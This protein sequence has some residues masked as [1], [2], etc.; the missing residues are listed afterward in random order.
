MN[1]RRW[2]PI[3]EYALLLGSGAG[4]ITSIVTQNA[5]AASLPVTALVAFGLLNKRRVEQGLQA[6]DE[7]LDMLEDRVTHEV[8]DLANQ[9]SAL[10]T[11]ETITQVQRAAMEHSDSAIIRFSHVL[12]QTK[13]DM[14]LRLEE[15]ESPDLSHLYQDTAQL[16]DQYTYVC[17]AISNLSKQIEHLSRLP[18]ME[19]T[20]ADVTHLKTELMQMRVNLETLKSESKTAQATLHDAVRHLD[21]RLRRVPHNADPSMLK[22]EV[23]ELVKA[24]GDLVPRRE[25]SACTEKLQRVYET[26]ENL[27]QTVDRLQTDTSLAEQNGHGEGKG[28]TLKTLETDLTALTDAV[29][30]MEVRLADIAVPFDITTEIRAT[31]A[32]Y[33]SSL[34]W[35]LASLEQNTQDLIQKQQTLPSLPAKDVANH[36][37][38]LAAQNTT[39]PAGENPLQWLM[40]FRSDDTEQDWSNVDQALLQV[41][42]EV[43]ERA[44][45]VWPWS[46]AMSLDSRLIERFTEILE[47][48]CRLEIGWCHP[49][50]RRDGILLKTIAQQWEVTTA[51]RKLLKSTLNQLLP[52]KKKY[53]KHFSFKILGTNEQFLVCD[54][55]YAIVGLQALRAAS[56]T[57]PELDLRVKTL[58][59]SVIKRL[60]NRFDHPDMLTEDTA[61][62]FNRAVT[63][64]DLKDMAGAIADFSEVMNM[65]PDDA[66]AANNRGV[67]WAEKKQCQRAVEDFDQA[68]GLDPYLFAA[69]CNRGWLRLHQNQ[70]EMAVDDFNQAIK[71]E[72]SQAIPY[73]YRGTGRQK[74]GDSLGAI[75]DYTKTIQINSQ[76]AFP[77]CYRGAAYQ[78]QGNILGAITDLEMAASL[79]HAKEDH[80]ALAQVTQILSSLK[81]SEFTQQPLRLHS[82]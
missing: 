9:I 52:L 43:S 61:A 14:R 11:P 81:Q 80:R 4:A 55:K 23:R 28:T 46:S 69:R 3:T 59:A 66:V 44:V 5:I 77:Y 22:G 50:D 56:S 16:Q 76:V 25:F 70:P 36:G 29:E 58:E 78:R 53:P 32:T 2:L 7:R 18:R 19:A 24:V 34:Q 49:G 1:N 47:R 31:T 51:E 37:A 65:S 33:L 8:I 74:L 79:L 40:A 6:N 21:R 10:P 75:A 26:Q 68:I 82:A 73:F 57:F 41:L 60:L 67:I 17:T 30:Q 48:G 54:R 13:A 27:R 71:A 39:T 15:I 64:Y 35:Q 42:D 38:H 45:L 62:Y 63:R 72:P 20:E 12:E